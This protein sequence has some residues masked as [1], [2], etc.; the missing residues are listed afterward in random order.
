MSSHELVSFYTKRKELFSQQLAGTSSHINVV[1][2]AR[3]VIALL[4]ILFLYF[5]FTQDAGFF[6][7]LPFLAVAFIY[8]IR[9]HARLFEAKTHL[10]N[11]VRI[12]EEEL[13]S[14]SG[15]VSKLH[16]GVEFIDPGHPYSHDLDIFGVGSL[17]QWINRANTLIG[18]KK[19]AERLAS[20]LTSAN[21]IVSNQEAIREMSAMPDFRQDFQAAGKEIDERPLDREQLLAWLKHPAF[22]YGKS[23]YKII[24]T[25]VPAITLL[26]L[27]AA[28]FDIR[29]RPFVILLAIFQW[30]FLGLHIK[31]VNAFHDYISRKKNILQ[32]YAQLL[33]YVQR[34]NF[35]S[36]L[37]KDHA[38]KA[39]NA[40]VKVK[41]LASLVY[42][43]DARMN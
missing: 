7:I 32:K 18:R 22:L 36:A 4:F 11:L 15:D 41:K 2:N 27:V 34:E 8:L 26:L 20:P 23:S 30:G 14:L 16:S 5:G 17:Y 40:D 42:S 10:Q 35:T 9:R 38:A 24:L 28:F 39:H 33:H 31:K 6:I 12:N 21:E 37:L 43:L 1:S 3:L 29:F 19:F 25:V 13:K